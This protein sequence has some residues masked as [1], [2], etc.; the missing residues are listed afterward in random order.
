MTPLSKRKEAWE[1]ITSRFSSHLRPDDFETWIS[2]TRLTA[3]DA[4]MAVIE[5][6]NRFYADW[7]KEHYLPELLAAF[8]EVAAVSPEIRFTIR[9]GPP[10][11]AAFSSLEAG[12]PHPA[13]RPDLRPDMTFDSFVRS[14]ANAFAYFS[15]LEIADNNPRSY[16]P[17]FLFSEKS[18]GKTHLLHA[19]G[20]RVA[21]ERPDSLIRYVHAD[22]FTSEFTRAIRAD[23]VHPFRSAYAELDLLLVD[24]IHLLAGR[25]KTQQELTFVVNALLREG[26]RVTVAGKVP[27]FRLPDADPRMKSIL[28]WGLL[29]EIHP[30]EPDTRVQVIRRLSEREQILLP[31]DI[32]FFLAKS[33]DDMKH[34]LGNVTRVQTY[35]SLNGSIDLS[36]VRSLIRDPLGR[37]AEIGDIQAITAGYFNIPLSDL[38]SGKRQRTVAYPRQMAMYLCKKYTGLSYKRIGNAFE[39]KDHSTVIYAVRRIEQELAR[40]RDVREDLKNLEHLIG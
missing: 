10:A 23:R 33:N 35:V 17:L 30:P 24:D 2:P 8:E 31:D 27:P 1:R 13:R 28:S 21:G 29:A 14:R 18:S 26:K 34:L 36:A 32:I 38:S 15:C 11:G 25:E 3:L 40:R 20:N 9:N 22:R 37:G 6:P 39:K 16:A 7:I 19:L 12:L 5:V 4:D